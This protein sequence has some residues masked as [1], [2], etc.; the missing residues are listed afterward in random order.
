VWVVS[1]NLVTNSQANF[2]VTRFSPSGEK[3]WE[4]KSP[5]TVETSTLNMNQ[6]LYTFDEEGYMNFSYVKGRDY[7]GTPTYFRLSPEGTAVDE[8]QRDHYF[9]KVS[10]TGDYYHAVQI[11]YSEELRRNELYFLKFNKEME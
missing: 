5:E 4:Y 1:K 8:Y 9:S 6:Y 11:R 3:L 7:G 10:H 2:V